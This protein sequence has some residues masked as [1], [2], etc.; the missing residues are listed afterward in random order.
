MAT[1]ICSDIHGMYDKFIKML[2]KIE[3]SDNDNLYVIGDVIDRGSNSIKILQHIINSHNIHM[4]IGNHENS[5]LDYYRGKWVHES[6][7]DHEWFSFGGE[8]T[9]KEFNSLSKSEKKHILD[10][11]ETLPDYKIIDNFILVHGGFY[12]E[13]KIIS[14]EDALKNSNREEKVW[15][16]EFFEEDITIDGYTV[17]CGHT[18]TK[19]FGSDYIIHKNNKILI[20]CGCYYGGKLACIRI[21]DMKEFYV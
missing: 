21:D 7:A 12:A 13:S 2:N 3:F 10:Y 6:W 4:I 1:Y 11:L 9:R 17:I 8:S 14:L 20:D 18:P 16:R 5:M 19:F 15:N